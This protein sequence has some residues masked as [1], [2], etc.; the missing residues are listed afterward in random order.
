MKPDFRVV[1]LAQD[2]SNKTA[3]NV[4]HLAME[5]PWEDRIDALGKIIS[6]HGGAGKIIV[7][8]STKADANELMRTET[9]EN[10]IEVMHGGIAQPQREVT[11]KRFKAGKFQ[12]L[13]ATD[14]ASRGL[15]IPQVDLVVQ[16][17]PPKD[18]E[19][20]IHRAGRTARAGR[21][22]LCITLYNS[23]NE[24]N[25][26][27]AEDL[28]G[29]EI[30][31]VYVPTEDEATEARQKTKPVQQ[32]FSLT[33]SHLTGEAS[34]ATME[35]TMLEEGKELDE[36]SA[37]ALIQTYWAPRVVDQVRTI[38]TR[39][40]KTGVVF[41]LQARSAEGFIECYQNLKEKNPARVDFEV[42]LC[43]KLPELEEESGT[44]HEATF[45]AA[46]GYGEVREYAD[47]EAGAGEGEE[48]GQC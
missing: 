19:S 34:K 37:F 39:K 3:K 45:N 4:K 35:M 33:K 32:D 8:T 1:D 26:T 21:S 30:E 42:G 6:V 24:E 12:V 27:K 29:I 10:D 28:A 9:I 31:R 41:D 13:V 36:T 15:D 5:C 11:I 40:D 23:G 38:R 20:Y 7:F 48:D 43:L 2:L 18:T 46:G 25:L 14:V 16:I 17:E 44:Q 22:G 47:K